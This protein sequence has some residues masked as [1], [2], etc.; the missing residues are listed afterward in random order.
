MAVIYFDEQDSNAQIAFMP[1]TD[2]LSFAHLE[3]VD[4]GDIRLARVDAEVDDLQVSLDGKSIILLDVPPEGL[5]HSDFVW[6]GSGFVIVGDNDPADD[7]G[8][9][10]AGA[11]DING[12]NVG[13]YLAGLA[14][15]DTVNALAG[16]DVIDLSAG[17]SGQ[18]GHDVVNGGDGTDLLYFGATMTKGVTVNLA[19]GTVTGGAASSGATLTSIEDVSGSTFADR[20]T[21]DGIANKLSGEGGN[22]TLSGAAGNDNLAGGAGADNLNGGVGNDVLDGG[23]G[24]DALA[25]SAGN[26][27]MAWGA[28]DSFNGG[29]GTDTLKVGSGNINL[30][31]VDNAKLKLTEQIDLRAGSHTLTINKSDVFDMSANH[32][33]KILGD[34]GDTVNLPGTPGH[35]GPVGGFVDYNLGGGAHL[36]IDADINVV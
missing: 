33:V 16:D 6:S 14:G 35:T 9:S 30:S 18:Y 21:G 29:D 28:G 5:T 11:N 22:D 13:D 15:N 25:G 26:D 34:A 20:L 27:T 19:T 3:G 12:T 7:D 24:S 36:L 31:V 1:G 17:L 10:D 23:S 2:V 4:A 32:T 8:D